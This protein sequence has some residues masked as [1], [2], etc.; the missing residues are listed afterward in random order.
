MDRRGARFLFIFAIGSLLLSFAGCVGKSTT[1]TEGGGVQTVTLAPTGNVSLELG[2]IQNF[3]AAARNASGG[4]VIT[5]INFI[6]GCTD[7]QPCAPISIANNG[8]ACAC[9][10]DSL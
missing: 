3:S 4:A 10:W 7:Q 9:T 5:T 2:K 1:N 6:S 8:Q